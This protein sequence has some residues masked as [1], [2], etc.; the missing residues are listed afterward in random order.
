M[1]GQGRQHIGIEAEPT[2]LRH[3]VVIRTTIE[4]SRR[5][6]FGAG[7]LVEVAMDSEYI[8][9]ARGCRVLLGNSNGQTQLAGASGQGFE[10]ERTM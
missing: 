5:T 2:G 8:F 7:M 9:G 1:L 3:K 4:C 6:R 10:G